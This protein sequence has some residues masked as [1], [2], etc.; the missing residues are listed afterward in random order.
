MYMRDVGRRTLHASSVAGK[1]VFTAFFG[2]PSQDAINK[3]VHALRE[4]TMT[5]SWRCSFS[6][7]GIYVWLS[8]EMHKTDVIQ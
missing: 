1:L 4:R 6:R 7:Y 5:A 3:G 8:K 2:P